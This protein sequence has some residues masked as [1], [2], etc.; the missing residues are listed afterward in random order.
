MGIFKSL[1]KATSVAS[2]SKN[3][4]EVKKVNTDASIYL[5]LLVLMEQHIK[6]TSSEL[7][8]NQIAGNRKA[9]KAEYKKLCD[10]GLAN[11]KNAKV[12][13]NKLESIEESE[14]NRDHA[15]AT[16]AFIKD[17][18]SHFGNNVLLM[19]F[20]QFNDLLSKYNLKIGLLNNYTGVIPSK[21]ICELE[22]TIE[23]LNS[24]YH[25]NK[26]NYLADNIAAF[27]VKYCR[28]SGVFNAADDEYEL[29]KEWLKSKNGIVFVDTDTYYDNYTLNSLQGCNLDLP[30]DLV[31]YEY[32]NLYSLTGDKIGFK[33]LLIACPESQL[34]EQPITFTSNTFDPIVFQ[35]SPYGIVVY[36]VWGE[37]SEDKVF[38]E[39]K[40]INE[41]LAI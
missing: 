4:L 6:N 19:G 27:N 35:Y 21:N 14:N 10:L 3:T 37:E 13:Q 17:L 22:S 20:Q 11:T 5:Q 12:I 8:I 18:R 31:N 32:G 41:L 24:F 23:K 28:Y 9:L 2:V 7:A 40:K 39:Y 1:F 36:S 34:Q 29:L 25:R 16:L 30:G 33:T 26:Q 15:V 38:E